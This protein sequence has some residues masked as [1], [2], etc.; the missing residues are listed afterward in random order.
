MGVSIDIDWAELITP[1][2]PRAGKI[3][4]RV[5]EVGR[6]GTI[7]VGDRLPRNA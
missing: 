6:K 1:Q 4:G 3:G 7:G 5:H 2:L